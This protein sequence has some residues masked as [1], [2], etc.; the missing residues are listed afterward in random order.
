M[1]PCAGINVPLKVKKTK[2]GTVHQT[3]VPGCVWRPQWFMMIYCT[4][5]QVQPPPPPHTHWHAVKILLSQGRQ[6]TP[7]KLP[8]A[9]LSPEPVFVNLLRSPGIDSQPGGWVQQPYWSYP[10]ARLYRQ[11]E[12][13]TRNRFL[14]SKN[15]Y[16]YGLWSNL[17]VTS[18]V[19][20]APSVGW[21]FPHLIPRDY[22]QQ[23]YSTVNLNLSKRMSLQLQSIAHSQIHWVP[24]W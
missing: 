15:V 1:S 3:P 17:C 8:T 10:A 13:I 2:K 24:H 18:E 6:P 12:S 4:G 11:A 20:G 14:G 21:I 7:L 19:G 22:K 5:V 23:S 9:S 16:K